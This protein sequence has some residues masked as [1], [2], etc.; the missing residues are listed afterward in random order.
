MSFCF[1][2]KKGWQ[3]EQISVL[4]FRLGGAG[5]E[6]LSAPGISPSR[7]GTWDEFLLSY[8]SS[9]GGHVAPAVR[10][11]LSES[12]E[13]STFDFFFQDIFAAGEQPPKKLCLP[14]IKNSQ[15]LLFIAKLQKLIFRQV[16]AKGSRGGVAALRRT[17]GIRRLDSEIA[18]KWHLPHRLMES[19]NA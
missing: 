16:K 11:Y 8:T 12:L 1:P 9:S 14:T 18:E 13:V 19:R 15:F 3:A 2:V 10:N 5:L 6:D 7:R 4:I 17:K